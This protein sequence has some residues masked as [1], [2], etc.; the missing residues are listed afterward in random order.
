M[1]SIAISEFRT[2]RDPMSLKPRNFFQ[3]H[4]TVG[5]LTEPN[6]SHLCLTRPSTSRIE[7]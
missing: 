1:I 2:V 5:R 6:S 4:L 7:R 3:Q